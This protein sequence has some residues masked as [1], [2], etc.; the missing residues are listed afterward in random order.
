MFSNASGILKI[1][2]LLRNVFVT[3]STVWD[4]Q[5]RV[6]QASTHSLDE[7]HILLDCGHLGLAP[8]SLV[9]GYQ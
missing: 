3:L 5:S 1:T 9:H 4:F 2:E 8:C 6:T 7:R